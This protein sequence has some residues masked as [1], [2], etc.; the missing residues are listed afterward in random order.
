MCLVPSIFPLTLTI[1]SVSEENPPTF[2][3]IMLLTLCFM[4]GIGYEGYNAVVFLHTA[5]CK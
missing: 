1:F 3:H 4:V 5:F 2:T